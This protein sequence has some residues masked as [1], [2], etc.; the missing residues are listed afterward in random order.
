V[1]PEFRVPEFRVAMR[2][3]RVLID[4]R[5]VEVRFLDNAE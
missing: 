4:G 2:E 5:E 3:G 1:S